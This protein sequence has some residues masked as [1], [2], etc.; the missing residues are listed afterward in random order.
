MDDKKK[1][2]MRFDILKSHP[3]GA[4]SIDTA[5]EIIKLWRK[6]TM[7]MDPTLAD[8]MLAREMAFMTILTVEAGRETMQKIATLDSI[9]GEISKMLGRVQGRREVV[10]QVNKIS[11]N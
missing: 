5:T 11:P 2:E 1:R 10:D 3:M 9:L 8:E 7:D 6:D 4:V